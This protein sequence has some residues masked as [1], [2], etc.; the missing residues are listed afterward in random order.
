MTAFNTS[1][2]LHNRLPI[3]CEQSEGN[4]EVDA[5]YPCFPSQVLAWSGSTDPA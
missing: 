4:C 3:L 1:L 5:H 2:P